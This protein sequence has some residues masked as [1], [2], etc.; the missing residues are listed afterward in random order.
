M[1]TPKTPQAVEK[2]QREPRIWVD[3]AFWLALA[4][5]ALA[6]VLTCVTLH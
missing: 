2:R 1:T 4:V 3:G 5:P 6:I